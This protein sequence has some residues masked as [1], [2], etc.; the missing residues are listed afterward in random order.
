MNESQ[1]SGHDGGTHSKAEERLGGWG[2]GGGVQNKTSELIAR[3]G[4]SRRR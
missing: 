2:G 3:L 4:W 1:G